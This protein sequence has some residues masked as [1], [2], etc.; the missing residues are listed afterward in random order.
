MRISGDDSIFSSFFSGVCAYVYVCGYVICVQVQST[1]TYVDRH[2]C[3]YVC[4]GEHTCLF[5]GDQRTTSVYTQEHC[6]FSLRWNLSLPWN[7][8]G[9]Y[10]QA[11][12]A[13]HSYHHLSCTG[14]Q[15]CD[16]AY[17]SKNNC[18]QLILFFGNFIRLCN[19]F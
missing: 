19:I 4:R 1:C 6:L 17:Y 3:V 8:P 13:D 10:P 16:H 14:L 2:I 9:G 11:R 15:V 7:C 12:L 18:N 5:I